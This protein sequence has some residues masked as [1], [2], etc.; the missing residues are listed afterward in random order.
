MTS[1]LA[2]YLEGNLVETASA[3]I[4]QNELTWLLAGGPENRS[5]DYSYSSSLGF[6]S[7]TVVTSSFSNGVVSGLSANY[8]GITGRNALDFSTDGAYTDITLLSPAAMN[9]IVNDCIAKTGWT[10][11]P[12]LATATYPSTSV[13]AVRAMNLA[14]YTGMDY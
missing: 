1:R 11:D 6:S 5:F 14:I 10:S 9:Q 7:R 12:P 13:E 3:G 8:S 2:V 4:P